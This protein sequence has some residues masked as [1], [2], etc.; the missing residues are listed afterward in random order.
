MIEE[1]EWLF[2]NYEQS[3]NDSIFEIRDKNEEEMSFSKEKIID[4]KDLV[5]EE[6]KK[7][8]TLGITTRTSRFN[9]AQL[10][11][12]ERQIELQKYLVEDDSSFENANIFS[13]FCEAR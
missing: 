2:W 3:K 7:T 10:V 1:F 13:I 12:V 11:L 4:W 8:K 6:E 9:S 5:F